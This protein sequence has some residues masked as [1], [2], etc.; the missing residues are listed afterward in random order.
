VSKKLMGW[1]DPALLLYGLPLERNR[2]RARI[3]E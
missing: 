3:I 2:L 1:S